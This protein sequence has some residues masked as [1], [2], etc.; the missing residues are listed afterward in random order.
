MLRC[1][2]AKIRHR[3]STHAQSH[4][5]VYP[6]SAL[7]VV[8]GIPGQLDVSTWADT[9][10]SM[11]RT[12]PPQFQAA[13]SYP[14][15]PRCQSSELERLRLQEFFDPVTPQLPAI[16]RLLVPTERRGRVE[17]PTIDIHLTRSDLPGYTLRPI[18]IS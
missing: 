12:A 11:E 15:S 13:S 7:D 9:R 10:V 4:R 18:T 2:D 5:S 6:R 17:A 3:A 14:A 16:A 1:L 8:I